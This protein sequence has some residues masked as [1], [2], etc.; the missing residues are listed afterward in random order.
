MIAVIQEY[1]PDL[2]L[3]Q[4]HWLMKVSF[5]EIEAHLFQFSKT[6]FSIH[7]DNK[8][9]TLILLSQTATR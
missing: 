5:L 3:M 1:F 2:A 4:F 6:L 9:V 7:F 8:V